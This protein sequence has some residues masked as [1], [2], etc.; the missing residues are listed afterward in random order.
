MGTAGMTGRAPGR[1]GEGEVA[2][3]GEL[4]E[5]AMPVQGM[6]C[7]NCRSYVRRTLESVAGV[8]AARVEPATDLVKV[9]F[10]P[11]RVTLAMLQDA[12]E[13]IGYV[14][15]EPVAITD[16]P[17]AEDGAQDKSTAG[18]KSG[19]ARP[20]IFGF[21]ASSLL[22]AFY[23]GL[24]T[25]AQGFE[26]AAG[27]LLQDWYFVVPIVVGFGLQVG[28]FVHLRAISRRQGTRSA[29]ALTGVGTG[30][31]SVSMVA[32]CAHHVTDILPLV[33]ISG[34]ALFLNDYRQPLMLL[35]IATNLAG[36]AIMGRM[37]RR[38]RRTGCAG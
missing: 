1:G 24:V 16:S 29:T 7:S 5:L 12:V 35:G 14:P 37:I 11:A 27:L 4:V 10:D 2:E 36:I 19:V 32:C 26:H 17:L 3:L 33:G 34:A 8:T 21:L 38:M 23:A 28:L 20:I 31:S 6:T 13:A 25:V 22:V 30:T 9:T 15:G 18:R